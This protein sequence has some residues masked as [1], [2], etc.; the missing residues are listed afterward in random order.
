[1]IEWHK[2]H[3][4]PKHAGGTDDPSNII[5]CN[6]AC[7]AMLHKIR[8]EETGDVYDK[9]AWLSLTKRIGQQEAEQLAAKEG[10]ARWAK[11]NPEQL[12]EITSK[13]GKACKDRSAWVKAGRE[14][15]TKTWEVTHPDGTVEAVR[16]LRGFCRDRG[17]DGANLSNR[18]KSHGY[19]A[20]IISDG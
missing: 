9:I 3:I 19:T 16:N 12:R 10:R 18:G 4:I 11:E 5:K 2:H 7:H 15:P 6:I 20:R 1:M 14:A 17:F 8:Y 13:G